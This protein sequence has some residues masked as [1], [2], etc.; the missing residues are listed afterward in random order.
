MI[1]Y[2]YTDVKFIILK[3]YDRKLMSHLHDKRIR[4]KKRNTHTHNP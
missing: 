3:N 4:G 1:F 2:K